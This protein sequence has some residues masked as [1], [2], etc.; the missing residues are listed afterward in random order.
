MLS[1]TKEHGCSTLMTNGEELRSEANILNFIR[2]KKGKGM[3]DF[4]KL[5]KENAKNANSDRRAQAVNP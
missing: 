4:S 5:R 3:F 1:P 2:S